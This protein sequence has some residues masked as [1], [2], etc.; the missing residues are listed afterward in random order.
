MPIKHKCKSSEIQFILYN[1]QE[2]VG[3]IQESFGMKKGDGSTFWR[4]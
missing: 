2:E 3:N 4:G 1:L